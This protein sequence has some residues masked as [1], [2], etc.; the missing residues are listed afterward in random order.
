MQ[1]HGPG[2][3]LAEQ[4]HVWERFHRV[5]GVEVCSGSGVGLGL[6]LYISRAIIEY[7]HGQVGVESLPGA[8]ATFWFAPPCANTEGRDRGSGR[9]RSEGAGGDTR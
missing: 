9:S 7:H 5:P 3:P 8:G 4:E 2:I 1:D 6:G